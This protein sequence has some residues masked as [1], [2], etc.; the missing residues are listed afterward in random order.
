MA[1]TAA[2]LEHAWGRTGEASPKCAGIESPASPASPEHRAQRRLPLTPARREAVLEIV[3]AGEGGIEEMAVH[4]DDREVVWALLRFDLGSGSFARGKV[5]LLH[6]NGD[7]CP[8]VKR[9]RANALTGQ[10]KAQLTGD[11]TDG[12]HASIQLTRREEVT[13][14][15]IVSMVSDC[16]VV[17]NI[18]GYKNKGWAMR[19]LP[20]NSVTPGGSASVP[21][22]FPEAEPVAP[23]E[24]IAPPPAAAV[25]EAPPSSGESGL[26]EAKEEGGKTATA[27]P[28]PRP[29]LLY[30][31]GRDALRGI[32]SGGPWNW[33]LLG[34]DVKELPL[35]G[36]GAGSVDEMRNCAREHQDLV[37]FGLLR[38]GFGIGR[39]KRT[40]Y[41]VVHVIGG[42]VPVVR[43]GRL[44]A[45]LPAMEEA[46]RFFAPCSACMTDLSS[47]D[48]DPEQ[49]LNRIRQVSV[50][51]DDCLSRDEACQSIFSLEAFRLAL[52]HEQDAHEAAA[53]A[54]AAVDSGPQHPQHHSP[55]TP[56]TPAAAELVTEQAQTPGAAGAP[57][58]P[59]DGTPPSATVDHT[60]QALVSPNG[61]QSTVEDVAETVRLVRH[62]DFYNWAIFRAVMPGRSSGVTMSPPACV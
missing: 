18:E 24:S 53:A 5:V 33:V 35:L 59:Q 31:S 6:F 25:V 44:N 28:A 29:P 45:L 40:K 14:E 62:E 51:D 19:E 16:F 46:F 11:H 37:T 20:Q 12:F 23:A 30:D 49:V 47:D 38:L 56:A 27:A 42:Q 22:S 2:L 9:A 36:G 58:A 8:A 41:I 57:P 7:D 34:P 21:H 61:P 43:R 1:Q 54:N 39:L 52:K 26:G 13:T 55:P 50:V 4:L 60:A 17:D 3:A 15:N 10:V 32:A 48:L